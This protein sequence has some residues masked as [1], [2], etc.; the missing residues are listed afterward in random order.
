MQH[1]DIGVAAGP[2]M[3]FGRTTFRAQ[4]AGPVPRGCEQ[5]F[6]DHM[7]CAVTTS[8]GRSGRLSLAWDDRMIRRHLLYTNAG[9][10]G[11]LHSHHTVTEPEGDADA[12][13]P[14]GAI[15]RY[16]SF[17]AGIS[18]VAYARIGLTPLRGPDVLLTYHLGPALVLG[19]TESP[20]GTINYATLSAYTGIEVATI[21]ARFE[22]AS[23]G[24][25]AGADERRPIAV[26]VLSGPDV[27]K[28]RPSQVAVSAGCRVM[29]SL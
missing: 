12:T 24:I 19:T 15:P 26:E 17:A 25:Y 5:S 4:R 3:S 9:F 16:R 22:G 7:S 20:V 14:D 13:S 23:I 10:L 21:I 28:L 2:E 8:S 29:I 11:G 6:G 1:H 18:G 27:T